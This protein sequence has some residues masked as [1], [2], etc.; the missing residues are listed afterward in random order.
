M[1]SAGVGICHGLPRWRILPGM[2]QL[3]PPAPPRPEPRLRDKFYGLPRWVQ[4]TA[5]VVFAGAAYGFWR[6]L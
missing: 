2:D 1:A 3:P 4:S 6:W 5:V